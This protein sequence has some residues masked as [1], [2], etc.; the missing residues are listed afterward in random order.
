LKIALQNVQRKEVSKES[1]LEPAQNVASKPL[2]KNYT[3][4]K[5]LESSLEENLS[6]K[7]VLCFGLKFGI[8]YTLCGLLV[9]G[10]TDFLR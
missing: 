8:A 4:S 9:P 1:Y 6:F 7:F 5:S 10:V 2:P 3:V